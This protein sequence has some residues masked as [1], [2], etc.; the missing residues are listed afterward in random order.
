MNAFLLPSFRVWPKRAYGRVAH[1][2]S[3]RFL[4]MAVPPA[5]ADACAT[6]DMPHADGKCGARAGMA[7]AM[8]KPI[9]PKACSKQWRNDLLAEIRRWVASNPNKHPRTACARGVTKEEARL[10]QM[11]KDLRK[12]SCN[13]LAMSSAERSGWDSVAAWVLSA[14]A[15]TTSGVAYVNGVHGRAI[16]WLEHHPYLPFS[17]KKCSTGANV[18]I[19][20]IAKVRKLWAELSI[21]VKEKFEEL[22]GWRRGIPRQHVTNEM[23]PGKRAR[24]PR[25]CTASRHAIRWLDRTTALG[26]ADLNAWCP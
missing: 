1:I 23:M 16:N 11:I 10:A 24:T 17:K 18:L 20:A 8:C 4:A 9:K 15:S 19:K 2:A 12:R 25:H 5:S 6:A 14:K 13:V 7:V 3:A 26:H 22:P 21:D